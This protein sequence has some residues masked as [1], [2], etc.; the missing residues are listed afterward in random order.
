MMSG[1]RIQVD[2]PVTI[3]DLGTQTVA[4][5]L[6]VP[7]QPR[8]NSLQLL[9]HGA[10]YSHHYWDFP[11]KPGIYSY[12]EF[13][14][15]AGAATLTI[16]QLG[17]GESSRPPGDRVTFFALAE[18]V[19]GVVEAAKGDGLAGHR[20]ERVALIG[21]SA[22]SL[23]SGLEAATYQ[24]VDAVVLTGMLGPN[25][26]GIT[27]NDPRIAG[28]FVPA[29]SDSVL[30]GKPGLQDPN[31]LTLLPA[32]RVPLF[33]RQPPAEPELIALDESLKEIMTTGQ[34]ATFGAAA[35]A[36]GQIRC[37]TLVVN[38]RYD[39]FFYDPATEEDI[40]ANIA[41]AQ[42][43]AADNYSF[44]PL[45]DD[46]GHNL[47]QH[48]GAPAVYRAI[49]QWLHTQ[50]PHSPDSTLRHQDGARLGGADNDPSRAQ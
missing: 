44:L 45:F 3:K 31:Y 40:S 22:G 18:A 11:Y 27:D 35:D 19:H 32:V 46:M 43:A 48:P 23:T 36:C 5:W 17:V 24:D 39:R 6:A 9:I 20:F 30:A 10:A 14:L 7:D 49:Q 41:R 12:V 4:G 28:A 13:A 33:F 37:P 16:D 25:A 34:S 29:A 50:D 1:Q 26:S 2:I 21:H 42:A 8:D 47:N 15:A 38:G